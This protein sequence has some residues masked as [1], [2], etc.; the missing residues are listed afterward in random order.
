MLKL[1]VV[2]L[3]IL[4]LSLSWNIHTLHQRNSH[5]T[6]MTLQ[7]FELNDYTFIY[8][9]H[10]TSKL[11]VDY[12]RP[13]DVKCPFPLSTP[14]ICVFC[15]TNQHVE[16]SAG[17]FLKRHPLHCPGMWHCA[18]C[19]G[20][21]CPNDNDRVYMKNPGC[22]CGWITREVT[23]S[24]WMRYVCPIKYCYFQTETHILQNGKR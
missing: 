22:A 19:K 2:T 18:N 13:L 8:G 16:L 11:Q 7:Q 12:R 4:L 20:E 15:K 9:K 5:T 14:P 24:D 3:N 17:S 21:I 1:E 10:K 6:D 23:D